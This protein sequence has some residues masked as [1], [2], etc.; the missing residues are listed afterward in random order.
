M[1]RKCRMIN[2]SPIIKPEIIASV[3]SSESGRFINKCYIA[4]VKRSKKTSPS[5]NVSASQMIPRVNL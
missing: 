3:H 4:Q 2:P 1:E 5:V